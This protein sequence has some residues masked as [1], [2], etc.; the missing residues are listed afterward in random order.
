[1]DDNTN[2]EPNT[3]TVGDQLKALLAADI[4]H[5]IG[6]DLPPMIGAFS[7][8]AEYTGGTGQ[9]SFLSLTDADLPPW[10]ELGLLETRMAILKTG[11][12]AAIRR[13]YGDETE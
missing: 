11:M 8:V 2:I 12:D 13:R 3:V 4:Q 6:T 10:Q 1:M 9:V 7:L 5:R